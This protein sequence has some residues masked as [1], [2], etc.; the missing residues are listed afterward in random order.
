M[1]IT[2]HLFTFRFDFDYEYSDAEWLFIL[3][4]K[5]KSVLA[6]LRRGV[7]IQL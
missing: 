1:K 4:A 3:T 6:G 5:Y 7:E 2:N